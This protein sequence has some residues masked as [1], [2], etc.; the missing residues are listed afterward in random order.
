MGGSISTF[1]DLSHHSLFS[2][3][4]G[5]FIPENQHLH[6]SFNDLSLVSDSVFLISKCKCFNMYG[7]ARIPKV[8]NEYF[9]TKFWYVST[10]KS[11]E[12]QSTQNILLLA[13]KKFHSLS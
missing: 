12:M 9:S 8:N 7:K 5:Y 10:Q 6:K 11:N 13:L 4:E 1:R 3:L 2:L